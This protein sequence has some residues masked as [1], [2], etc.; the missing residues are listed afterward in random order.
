MS[1]LWFSLNVEARVDAP[2]RF[3]GGCGQARPA[4]TFSPAEDLTADGL[5]IPGGGL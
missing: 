2:A 5:S 4:A 1:D 3:C